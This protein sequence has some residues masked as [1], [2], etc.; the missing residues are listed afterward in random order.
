MHTELLP[1]SAATHNKATLFKR[2]VTTTITSQYNKVHALSV[3]NICICRG[4]RMNSS[5]YF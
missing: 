5:A 2:R 1:L 3:L 4:A